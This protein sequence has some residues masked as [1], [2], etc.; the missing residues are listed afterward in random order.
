MKKITHV[1]KKDHALQY[2]SCTPKEWDK[3]IKDMFAKIKAGKQKSFL[4][5]STFVA[6]IHE[7]ENMK[8]PREKIAK[9]MELFLLYKGIIMHDKKLCIN[10]L[11]CY[12]QDNSSIEQALAKVLQNG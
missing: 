1:L 9:Y 4:L 5:E 7:L 2:L 10:A 3:S 6:L 12:A 11:Q 8:A